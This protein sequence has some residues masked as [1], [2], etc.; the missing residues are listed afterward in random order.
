MTETS[1]DI[2]EADLID[3]I[4]R[5]REIAQPMPAAPA[6]AELPDRLRHLCSLAQRSGVPETW[7]TQTA[8][9]I[10]DALMA[11]QNFERNIDP[12]RRRSQARAQHMAITAEA[13]RAAGHTRGDAVAALCERYGRSRSRVYA[14]LKIKS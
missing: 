12:R 1:H 7:I 8:D 2:T 9:S 11:L 3:M 4:R 10:L 6:S 13:M 14:L 5:K